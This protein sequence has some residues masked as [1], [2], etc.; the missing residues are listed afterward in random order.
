GR[1][2]DALD[3]VQRISSLSDRMASI[4]R[5]LRNFARKPNEKLGPVDVAEVV[6]DTLEII[7]WRL[8]AAGA[9]L[10]VELGD[11]PPVVHAGAVRLQQGLVNLVSSAA[12]AVDG[13]PG[14]TVD[15]V[16]SSAGRKVR[17][18]GRDR[19]PGIPAAG[20]K[21]IFDP[22]FTTKGVG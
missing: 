4:G 15:L 21:R 18:A 17:M 8:K 9:E 13:L 20:A 1:V 22:F 19:G 11:P 2:A 14:R 7:D 3:N 16:A 5:H 12:D 6:V 10:R